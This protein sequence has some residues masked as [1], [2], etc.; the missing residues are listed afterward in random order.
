MV[1]NCSNVV[2]I[3]YPNLGH[4]LFPNI[5]AIMASQPTPQKKKHGLLK[6]FLGDARLDVF[7]TRKSGCVVVA[8]TQNKTGKCGDGETYGGMSFWS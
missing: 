5:M 4:K 6:G 2:V 7:T 3:F 8:N 1:M